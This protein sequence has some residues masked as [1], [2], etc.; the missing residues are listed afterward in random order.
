MKTGEN[1]PYSVC[2]LNEDIARM[3]FK[4]ELWPGSICKCDVTIH[5]KPDG[6][7]VITVTEL[8]WNTGI[9]IGRAFEILL[10]QICQKYYIDPERVMYFERIL[11]RGSLVDRWF[12]VHFDVVENKVCNP[13]WQNVSY[14]FVRSAMTLSLTTQ[15]RY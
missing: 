11:E 15:D 6:S 4:C 13:H 10:D 8:P 2:R 9:S 7:K 3:L 14:S 1:D 5:C 12:L